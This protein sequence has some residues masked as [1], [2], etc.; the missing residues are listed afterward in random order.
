MRKS[1]SDR[2]DCP[3][4]GSRVTGH[5]TKKV[6]FS[7]SYE[8]LLFSISGDSSSSLASD[9]EFDVQNRMNHKIRRL[10]VSK[11]HHSDQEADAVS[12][13]EDRRYLTK[14]TKISDGIFQHRSGAKSD[15]RP[16]LLPFPEY[17]WCQPSKSHLME[18]ISR[19][20]QCPIVQYEGMCTRARKKLVEDAGEAMRCDSSSEL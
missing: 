17:W 16:R 6:Q 9:P 14:P 15:S 20:G 1:A 5:K 12:H 13:K 18:S 2:A 10:T 3:D 7:P 8:E 11:S 4:G 19:D